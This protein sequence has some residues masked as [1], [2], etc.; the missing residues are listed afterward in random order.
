MTSYEKNKNKETVH[1]IQKYQL[2]VDTWNLQSKEVHL[3]TQLDMFCWCKRSI[4]TYQTSN[5]KVNKRIPIPIVKDY[6]VW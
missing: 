5:K 2:W 3:W 6:Q 4:H 1:D